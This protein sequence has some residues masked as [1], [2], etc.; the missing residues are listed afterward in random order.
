VPVHGN[1]DAI[2]ECI[3]YLWDFM[4]GTGTVWSGFVVSGGILEEGMLCC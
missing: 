3:K 4:E 2:V 1:A